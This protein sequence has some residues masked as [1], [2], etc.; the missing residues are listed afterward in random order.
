[1]G[2]L[3]FRLVRRQLIR[4]STYPKYTLELTIGLVCHAGGSFAWFFPCLAFI[5]GRPCLDLDRFA[6]EVQS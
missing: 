5:A 1:M 6:G 4:E 2:I 3:K